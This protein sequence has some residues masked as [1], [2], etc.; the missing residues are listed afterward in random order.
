MGRGVFA[1]GCVRHEIGR[2]WQR[3]GSEIG[4]GR[5][6]PG[7]GEKE[8]SNNSDIFLG[9]GTGTSDSFLNDIFMRVTIL[10]SLRCKLMPALFHY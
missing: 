6:R 4:T 9:Y 8:T 10:K 5:V 3:M 1:T 2:L 7:R